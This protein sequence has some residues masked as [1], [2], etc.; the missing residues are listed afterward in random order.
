MHRLPTALCALTFLLASACGSYGGSTG[1]TMSPSPPPPPTAADI[2]IVQGAS[3]L[4]T[5]AFNPNPKTISLAGAMQV[6]VRWVNQDAGTGAYGSAGVSHQIASDDGSFATSEPFAPGG[7]FQVNLTKTG[8]YHYHCAIH[9]NMVGT[10]TV[11][12]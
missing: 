10:I 12:P 1:P 7:T 8:T 4:T 9:P 11:G 6:S 3:K 2:N 5:A